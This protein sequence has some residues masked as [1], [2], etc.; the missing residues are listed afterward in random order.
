[1]GLFQFNLMPFGLCNAPGTFQRMMDSILQEELNKDV[2]VYLEDVL[3]YGTTLDQTLTSWEKQL[4][5]IADAG[6]KCKPRKC[7]VLP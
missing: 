1:M 2:A 7:H 3:T 5:K 4:S 6:L